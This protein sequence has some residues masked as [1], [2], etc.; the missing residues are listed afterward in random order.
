VL[1]IGCG[2]GV[3]GVDHLSTL[4]QW[5]VNSGDA[6]GMKWWMHPWI[7]NGRRFPRVWKDVVTKGR[8]GSDFL[9][10]RKVG[11]GGK[12]KTCRSLLAGEPKRRW[13]DW[14]VLLLLLLLWAS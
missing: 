11:K 13:Y 14:R 6:V 7:V 9:Q 1:G 3:R 5:R 4:G 10:G 12:E 2:L 8:R